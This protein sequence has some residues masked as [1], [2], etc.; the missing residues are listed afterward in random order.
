MSHWLRRQL[1]HIISLILI[2]S[3]LAVY[4]LANPPASFSSLLIR[5][6]SAFL[7]H[8]LLSLLMR[9]A[10]NRGERLLEWM[11]G[12]IILFLA[13]YVWLVIDNKSDPSETL[14]YVIFIL[15]VVLAFMF[16]NVVEAI[17]VFRAMQSEGGD[18][19][20][21]QNRPRR[22]AGTVAIAAMAG[23]SFLQLV[24]QA[25]ETFS[26]EHPSGI[27]WSL[28]LPVAMLALFEFMRREIDRPY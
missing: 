20:F 13:L 22:F 6:S 9:R 10:R 2:P 21:S 8:I 3:F 1:H 15:T 4:N 17:R 27:S 23:F 18:I 7:P 26:L 16:G 28:L 5:L 14:E 25:I 24:R 19:Q 11:K 12:V